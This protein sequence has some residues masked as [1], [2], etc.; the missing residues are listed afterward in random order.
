[1]AVISV[2]V[3]IY[4]TEKLLGRCVDSI[5]AQTFQDI[6]LILVDDGSTDGSG[7]LCDE[8][9]G[10]D[11]R[12]TVLHQKNSGVGAARNAGLD[13]VRAYS[14]SRWIT[15][16]D[17]DDWAHPK[18]LEC[19]LNAAVSGDAQLSICGYQELSDGQLEVPEDI[20]E[21]E[22]WKPA[23]FYRQQQILAT[24]P[25]GKLYARSCFASIR[26]P[27]GTYFD[28]EYV[29]YRILFAQE[30]LPVVP[31]RLYAYYWNPEGLTKK[32]WNPRRMEVWQAYEQQIDFF[33][34]RADADMCAFRFREYL[35]NVYAQ[36]L[37]VRSAPEG[38]GKF[39]G[40]I[41]SHLRRL[42]WR[43]WRLSYIEFWVDYEMLSDC[44]PLAAKLGRL[45]M[46]RRGK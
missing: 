2:I 45:W 38:L 46:E 39:E 29:T 6:E 22:I 34:R 14:D 12:I 11:S 31:A 17:S 33:T 8:L 10:R 37:E 44:S 41:R 27:V 21:P 26:Y 24:V 36:L 42:I 23:D 18:M 5:L 32:P 28:D 35:E 30:Y 7:R 25:W 20:V 40:Q 43:A 9:A 4:N 19:L 15:F 16:V 1:M 3:P 13:W